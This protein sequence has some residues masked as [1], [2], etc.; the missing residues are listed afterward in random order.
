[1]TQPHQQQLVHNRNPLHSSGGAA[2]PA[3]AIYQSSA[4]DHRTESAAKSKWNVMFC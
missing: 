2:T 1:M 4:A 3:S